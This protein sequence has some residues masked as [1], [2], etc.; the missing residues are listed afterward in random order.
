MQADTGGFNT[1]RKTTVLEERTQHVIDRVL[2]TDTTG[3]GG[4]LERVGNYDGGRSLYFKKMVMV[5]GTNGS[6]D[7]AV[8]T[9]VEFVA[10]SKLAES[11]R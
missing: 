3:I 2:L 4:R 5:A 9:N 11:R 1:I 7:V 6:F 10:V 8:V